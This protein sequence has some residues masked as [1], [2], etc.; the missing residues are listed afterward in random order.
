MR[1]SSGTRSC[2][3]SGLTLVELMVAMVLGL[4]LTAA[5]IQVFAGSRS[6]NTVQGGMSRL[7][8]NARFALDALGRDIANAGFTRSFYRLSDGSENARLTLANTLNNVSAY[9]PL[10]FL[11][12]TSTASDTIEVNYESE[13]D[14]LGAPTPNGVASNQYFLEGTDLMCRGNGAATPGLIAEHV[15]NLQFLYGVDTDEDRVANS[16]VTADQLA[17]DSAIVA[18]KVAL[19]TS[20]G[21]PVGMDSGARYSLLDIP[22]VGPFNDRRLR[23]VF[24]RIIMLRNNT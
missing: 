20:T 14:C 4:L 21:D 22:A 16:F 17:S 6:S 11:P 18:V 8:E 24:S 15:E 1:H 10:L 2:H 23:Q 19:L 5:V 12:E 7:Q 9:P 3:Q 13:I